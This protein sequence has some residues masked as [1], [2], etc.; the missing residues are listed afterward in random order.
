MPIFLR[1]LLNARREITSGWM[2]NPPRIPTGIEGFDAL[3]EDGFPVESII[4]V[5]GSPGAGKTTFAAQFLVQGTMMSEKGLYVCFAETKESLCRNLLRF[6]WDF[7]DLERKGRLSIL[8]LSTTKEPGIQGNLN[9]ILEKIMEMNAKRL[10][11]DSFTAFSMALKEPTDVRFLIHLLYRFLQRAGCTT[12][13]ISDTPWGS[14]KI[15][16]GVEEFV[17]DG[18]VLLLTRFDEEGRLRRTCS[19]LKMRCTNHSRLTH[20]YEITDSGIRILPRYG[21]KD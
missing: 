13:M 7:Q 3:I 2:V 9:L 5:A 8:D 19:I 4:L 14:Q 18:I 11:I 16:S 1:K 12:V 21:P 6:G 15:G 17:A 10:V 20:E